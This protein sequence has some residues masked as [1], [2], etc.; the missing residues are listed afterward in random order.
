MAAPLGAAPP[1][2]PRSFADILSTPSPTS[3]TLKEPSRF[4]GMPCVSFTENDIE[5]LARRYRFALVG[6]FA[7]G[8]PSMAALRKAFD[9]IG[10]GGS[11]SLGLL[12]H[13]HVLIRFHREED[14]Q[15]CW[16]RRS[17]AIHDFTMRVFKWTPEF[18]PDLET[19]IVPIW[20]TFEG[21]PIYLH[22]KHALF[23]I[24]NLIGTPL[25]VDSS[26]LLLNRP[27]VARVCI[28]LDVSKD[29]PRT[30]WINNGSRGGFAQP[31]SYENLPSY[32]IRCKRFGHD[33]ETC[34]A[35]K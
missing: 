35:N 4:K 19:P 22:D 32:C 25:K 7:S 12:D 8:R 13:K 33:L 31:V 21:L 34:G 23:S 26:T 9:T 11:F 18:R 5:I 2:T 29:L 3:I 10:F 15:R 16:L 17:W 14:F 30:V 6:K 1:A 27:S 24:A 20:I 28:E